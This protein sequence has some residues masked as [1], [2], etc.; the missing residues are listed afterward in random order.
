MENY[1]C[2]LCGKTNVKLWR[3]YGHA[4]P[5]ICAEC[6]EKRQ[7]K[8]TCVVY[9]WEIHGVVLIGTP[10]GGT[11]ELEKWKIDDEGNIPSQFIYDPN[12][13]KPIELIEKLTVYLNDL[14]GNVGFQTSTL[15]VP[16]IKDEKGN[17]YFSE[18]VP[19]DKKEGWRK[20]PTRKK[21]NKK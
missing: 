14:T 18:D 5:L 15:L 17:F 11:I 21:D 3:P 8:R 7:V 19:I 16:A 1:S 20:L 4:V 13:K 2:S 10:T 9:E 12:A 6:A